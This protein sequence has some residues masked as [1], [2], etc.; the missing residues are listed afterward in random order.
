MQRLG[1]GKKK[2]MSGFVKGI[3]MGMRSGRV[4]LLSFT[5]IRPLTVFDT[6]AIYQACGF[7]GLLSS[8]MMIKCA[9]FKGAFSHDN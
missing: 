2:G 8:M 9:V 4:D 5:L 1:A 3:I 6:E 7:A